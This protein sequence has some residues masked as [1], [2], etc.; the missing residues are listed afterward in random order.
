MAGGAGMVLDV[1][2][3]GGG[4]VGSCVALASAERGDSLR[5]GLFEQFELGHSLGSSHGKSRIIRR[6]YPSDVFTRLMKLAYAQWE[7]I[8]AR[9]AGEPSGLSLIHRTGGLDLMPTGSPLEGILLAA[10]EKHGVSVEELTPTE[11]QERFGVVVDGGY[12]CLY[13]PDTGV[14]NADRCCSAV[15]ELCATS[16]VKV[17][18]RR[19]AVRVFHRCDG[20]WRPLTPGDGVEAPPDDVA[21]SDGCSVA[22]EFACTDPSLGR[23]PLWVFARSMVLCPGAWATRS[24]SALWGMTTTLP[25][26]DVVRVVVHYVKAHTRCEDIPVVIDYTNWTMPFSVPDDGPLP[27][28][29][30]G[31]SVGYRPVHPVYLLPSREMPGHIK[32]ACHHG[33]PLDAPGGDP[34]MRDFRV[35]PDDFA[36]RIQPWL[37]QRLPGVDASTAIHSETCLYTMTPTENFLIDDASAI[38]GDATGLAVAP[39]TF[40]VAGGM[41]GHGFKLGPVS[42]VIAASLAMRGTDGLSPDLREMLFDRGE[43]EGHIFSFARAKASV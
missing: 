39:G 5:V 38:I 20:G 35:P 34:A 19:A 40:V 30:V 1:A 9:M 6:T 17:V 32:V 12:R 8:S 42:G 3:V 14:L 29:D 37:E 28:E 26:L 24:L 7:E 18:E 16:G 13:Q 36:R 15:R 41:S 2:V 33:R 31:P 25:P 4:I 21:G 23:V 11:A 43:S 10:C 27:D 22:V